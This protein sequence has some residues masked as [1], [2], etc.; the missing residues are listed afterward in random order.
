MAGT[1]TGR[2]S[3][4]G[5]AIASAAIGEEVKLFLQDGTVFTGAVFSYDRKMDCIV[6]EEPHPQSTLKKD[7]RIVK[8]SLVTKIESLTPAPS[9]EDIQKLPVLTVEK[10]QQREREALRKAKEEL[11]KIG[12]GVTPEAQQLFDTL[13]KTYKLR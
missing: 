3:G 11:S 1:G 6:L 10:A 7:V 2:G 5:A 9:P 13:C 12:K 8:L 4:S